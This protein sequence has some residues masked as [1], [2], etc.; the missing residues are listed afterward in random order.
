M[1]NDTTTAVE[2]ATAD[3]AARAA[4]DPHRPAFHFVSP[5]GWLND[6]NGLTQR[7]GWYHLFYQYNPFDAVHDRIHWGHARSRDLLHWEHLPIALTPGDGPDADGCWSGVLVDDHGVPTLV[8]SG[9]RDGIELP[10]VATGSAD[11]LEWTTDAANPVIPAPPG[12]L[13]IVAFRD[14][15][16]W[17]E[18]DDGSWRHI[19]GSGI[20]GAGGTALLY[21]SDDLRSWRYVGPLLVGDVDAQPRTAPDWTGTMWECVDLFSVG[22]GAL[23]TDALVFSAW[24]DGVTHHPLYWTGRYRGDR[25]EPRALHRLDLGGR[26]FYAPQS[27][28]DEAGRRVMFGWMQEGR[29]DAAAVA[30]GW[31]GVMS[32][33]RV[34]TAEADGSLHQAPAPEVDALRAELLFD[35]EPSGLS[36]DAIEGDQLDLDI[37][38]ELEPGGSLDVT[39]CATPDGEERTVYRLRR[40]GDQAE[41]SLDRTR[42]SLDGTTDAKPL[43]GRIPLDG[44]VVRLRILVDHSA[45]EA[46]A[47]GVPLAA[48][49]YPTRGDAQGVTVDFD[50]ARAAVRAWRVSSAR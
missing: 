37:E 43:S 35:G 32:L 27:M 1:M 21:E 11:L 16:V 10:C 42:S 13:D 40:V 17:R 39:V 25:F 14:H 2:A 44:G 50:G 23:A 34:V 6:P 5:A 24:D 8:Y 26:F 36:R 47:N 46:F 28:R 45:L 18:P 9:R 41:F 7:D 33:P 22:S 31:S 20:R 30:A 3:L 29:T 12:D 38:A 19:V 49:V 4:L 15:C 48:R